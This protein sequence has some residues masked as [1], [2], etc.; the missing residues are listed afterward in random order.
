MKRDVHEPF[1]KVERIIKFSKDD[2]RK[3]SDFTSV[4]ESK[5]IDKKWQDCDALV[6]TDGN[7]IYQYA[8]EIPVV[9]YR[10]SEE[11][12][13]MPSSRL[14]AFI[15]S[16]TVSKVDFGKC[17][18][19]SYKRDMKAEDTGP[20]TVAYFTDNT[21]RVIAI[22]QYDILRFL[23]NKPDLVISNE[24]LLIFFTEKEIS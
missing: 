3:N 14:N 7:T 18:S 5:I 2:I 24:G 13:V 11:A 9:V 1:P 4:D 17:F 23:Q 22:Q 6:I 10:C 21:G 16:I 19:L 15:K 20:N 12:M 8:E